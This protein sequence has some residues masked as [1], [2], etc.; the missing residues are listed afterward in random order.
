MLNRSQF[1]KLLLFS[2]SSFLIL[3]LVLAY[4]NRLASDDFGIISNLEKNGYWEGIAQYYYTSDIRLLPVL[5]DFAFLY[6]HDCEHLL[7]VYGVL[8][9]A[10]ICFSFY[11][12]LKSLLSTMISAHFSKLFVL[13]ISVFLANVLFFATLNI[14]ET[15]FWFCASVCYLWSISFFC[16]G[17]G[18]ILSLKGNIFTYIGLAISFAYVAT[19]NPPFA[20]FTLLF[21]ILAGTFFIRKKKRSFLYKIWF[22]ILICGVGFTAYF[23]TPGLVERRSYFEE[24]GLLEAFWINTKSVGK[25][26][27]FM[28]PEKLPLIMLFA[29]PFVWVGNYFGNQKNTKK[30]SVRNFARQIIW[31]ALIYFAIVFIFNLPVSYI[32]T[33]IGPARA[34]A[35]VSLFTVMLF[36]FVAFYA[37][38]KLGLRDLFTTKITTIAVVACFAVNV[39]AAIHQYPI[40]KKYTHAY[41][42][43][44]SHLENYAGSEK[45]VE[46]EPLPSSGLLHSAEISSNPRDYRN[47][48]L[49]DYLQLD[50]DIIIK[51]KNQ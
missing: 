37:G 20:V 25:I 30:L 27:L 43:R 46:I 11:I 41:N 36:C 2:N 16:L 5:M 44:M 26:F 24:I 8:S 42:A 15:W 22:C 17:T 14:G 34:L 4:Y 1:N 29:I 49:R 38:Y 18:L 13:N 3:F 10:M 50:F 12:L 23:T 39:I 9:L 33:E 45:V 35:P 21:L 48:K 7:L 47:Y 51:E 31:L 6:F 40:V 19:S 32:M 28:L